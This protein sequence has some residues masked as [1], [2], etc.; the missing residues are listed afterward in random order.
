[1]T[2][3]E[4]KLRR[5]FKTDWNKVTKTHT[6]THTRSKIPC[7]IYHL[8]THSLSHTNTHTIPPP[9]RDNMLHGAVL[10]Q[11]MFSLPL[12][13][14]HPFMITLSYISLHFKYNSQNLLLFLLSSDLFRLIRQII[15]RHTEAQ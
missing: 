4:E 14:T 9:H 2:D 7:A 10:L 8:L 5:G 12:T 6:H 3:N 1:M 15:L 11:S 13:H